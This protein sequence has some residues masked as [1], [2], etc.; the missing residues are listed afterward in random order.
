MSVPVPKSLKV[1][2]P[3][4]SFLD[5]LKNFRN[6]FSTGEISFDDGGGI[7]SE[8]LIAVLALGG[9]MLAGNFLLK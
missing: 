5:G 3:D 2:D 7:G 8:I 9:G 4:T 1:S 6:T